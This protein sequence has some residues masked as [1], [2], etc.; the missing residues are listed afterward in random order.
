M[1]AVLYL[2]GEKLIAEGAI[3]ADA[4]FYLLLFLVLLMPINL[5]LEYYKYFIA[6]PSNSRGN[7]DALIRNFARGLT[8]RFI[9]P[10]K[11]GLAASVVLGAEK[12]AMKEVAWKLSLA[13]MAQFGCTII[14]G[15]VSFFL[16][17]KELASSLNLN[18]FAIA[19]IVLLTISV[20]AYF[21]RNLIASNIQVVKTASAAL[22]VKMASLSGLRYLV[23]LLQMV[24]AVFVL[25]PGISLVNALLVVPVLFLYTSLIPLGFLGNL[26]AREGLGVALFTLVL[27]HAEGV[28][29]ASVLVWII[30][31]FL[32]AILGGICYLVL[33]LRN[34][35]AV[36]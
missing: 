31:L 11:M 8:W 30:N 33:Q 18:V 21:F 20:L 6:L 35:Y 22:I 24:L 29:A 25:G 5:G 15:L 10:N 27:G 1:L 14:V 28:V 26:G 32:P 13:N 7:T 23:F 4:P 12:P 3:L 9:L 16:L 2:G 34:R 19:A 17:R 36:S